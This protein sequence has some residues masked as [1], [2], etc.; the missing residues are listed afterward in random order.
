MGFDRLGDLKSDYRDYGQQTGRGGGGGGDSSRGRSSRRVDFAELTRRIDHIKQK[1]AAAER[2]IDTVRV[3][4]RNAMDAI[5]SIQSDVKI[6]FRDD[7]VNRAKKMFAGIKAD[8]SALS[9]MKQK[10]LANAP[11]DEQKNIIQV[12]YQNLASSAKKAMGKYSAMIKDHADENRER[13]RKQYVIANPGATES[14]IQAAIYD[15]EADKAFGMAIKRSN[16]SGDAATVLKS[17]RERRDEV[18]KIEKA[19][20]ELAEMFEEMSNMVDEQQ[21]TLDTIEG[22]VEVAH[23]QVEEGHRD[24]KQA[25]VTAKKTRKLRWW[26]VGVL[27]V[28][29]IVVGVALYLKFKK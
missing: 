27:V 16:K 26:C 18:K 22:A 4:N 7:E 20:L 28:A 13:I 24:I 15:D 11:S 9:G 14:E 12:K 25:V 10:Y 19:I 21:V 8:L 17:V 5:G 1:I 3:A 6:A 23:E 2:Q 29:L